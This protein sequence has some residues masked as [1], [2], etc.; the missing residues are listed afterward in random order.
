MMYMETIGN[1]RRF[2]SAGPSFARNKP[3]IVVK[4]GQFKE[5]AKASLSHTGSMA[6]YDAAYD[7]AFKRA[8]VV[9][10]R[11]IS[12]LFDAAE[13]LH[14]KHLPSGPRLAIVTNAGG[15]GVVAT[16]VLISLGGKLAKLSKES[17]DRLSAFFLKRGAR[18]TL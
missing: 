7:V 18:A 2:M 10:V 15:P 16:D 6:G 4:P 14:S 13:V 3:I 17:T 9:R 1:A 11:E 5:S 12:H 8:G